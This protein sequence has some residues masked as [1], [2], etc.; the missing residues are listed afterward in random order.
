MKGM[1][2]VC[3]YLKGD[4]ICDSRKWQREPPEVKERVEERRKAR[5]EKV[6]RWEV[7]D[8]G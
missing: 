5:K 8:E 1:C 6:G 3:R 2:R 7:R 4:C